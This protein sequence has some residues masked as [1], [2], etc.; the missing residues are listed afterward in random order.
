M[1]PNV[2]Y[3]LWVIMMCQHRLTSYNKWATLVGDADN[4]GS[5]ARWWGEE[6]METLYRSLFCYE[7]KT[8]PVKLKLLIFFQW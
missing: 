1:N 8:I 3:R 7:P 5:G 2:N 6:Y 4:R